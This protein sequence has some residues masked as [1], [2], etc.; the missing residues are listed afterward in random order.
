MLYIQFNIVPLLMAFCSPSSK[1]IYRYHY[2]E[3]DTHKVVNVS[4]ILAEKIEL[5]F[6]DII[7]VF[8]LLF[9]SINNIFEILFN[10]IVIIALTTKHCVILL[11]KITCFIILIFMNLVYGT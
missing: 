10:V 6:K 4:Q 1:Q 8:E 11:N 2:T 9:R 7:G 3:D 5:F